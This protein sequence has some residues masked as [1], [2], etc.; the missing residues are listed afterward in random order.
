MLKLLAGLLEPTAG[1]IF[2]ND[3]PTSRMEKNSR[4]SKVSYAP[5][6]PHL[7]DAP[8][9]DNFTMFDTLDAARLKEFLSALNLPIDLDAAQKLSRGQLQRLGL[10]R[11]LLKDTPIILLD[12]P[13]AG[14]DEAT[15]RK[16]LALIKDCSL[17]RTIVIATHRTAVIE[18]ADE[19][20]HV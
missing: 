5:Q 20:A 7:F 2:W 12:E 8:L 11:A 10:I 14:L 6:A 18:F 17:R 13:T 4:L 16:V 9:M 3:V 15:E 19:V 1:E